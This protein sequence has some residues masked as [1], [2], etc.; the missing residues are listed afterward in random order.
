MSHKLLLKRETSSDAVETIAI[1]P[2]P[3][4]MPFFRGRQ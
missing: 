3:N 4:K 2:E 1:I